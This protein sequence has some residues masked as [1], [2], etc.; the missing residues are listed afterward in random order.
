[1]AGYILDLYFVLVGKVD[2]QACM[3]AQCLWVI[4]VQIRVPRYFLYKLLIRFASTVTGS[5]P[6]YL[7]RVIAVVTVS[8]A[9]Q[10]PA[11]PLIYL[12]V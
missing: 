11:A 4:V 8:L 6:Q 9:G 2:S 10:R 1:M 5:A 3:F 12:C 7:V